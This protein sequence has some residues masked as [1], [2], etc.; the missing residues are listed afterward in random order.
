VSDRERQR[1]RCFP[2]FQLIV[3][4]DQD[5][6]CVTMA[7]IYKRLNMGFSLSLAEVHQRGGKYV[8]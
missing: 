4:L 5:P 1:E 8:L 7:K 3:I 6:F 2:E